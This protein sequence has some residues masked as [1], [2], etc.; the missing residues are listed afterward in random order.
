MCGVALTGL[1]TNLT[2]LRASAL[3]GGAASNLSTLQTAAGLQPTQAGISEE[4][5]EG[6]IIVPPGGVL[7]LLSSGT[8]VAHSALAGLV[9]AEVPTT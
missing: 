2:L 4:H 7:A 3:I 8:A 1:S 5:I 9:W 6:S